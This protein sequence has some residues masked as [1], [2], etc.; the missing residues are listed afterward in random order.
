MSTSKGVLNY[1]DFI[2]GEDTRAML[3]KLYAANPTAGS[4]YSSEIAAAD[5]AHNRGKEQLKENHSNSKAALDKSKLAQKRAASYSYAKLLNYL[6][7]QLKAQGLHGQGVSQSALLGAYGNYRNAVSGIDTKH[8]DAVTALDAAYKTDLAGLDETRDKAYLGALQNYMTRVD[9]SS[10]R[11]ALNAKI[12]EDL[13]MKFAEAEAS[14]DWTEARKYFEKVKGFL[15]EDTAAFYT[16][17]VPEMAEMPVAG[18]NENALDDAGLH[19]FVYDYNAKHVGI[20][21]IQ[22]SDAGETLLPD[23][24]ISTEKGRSISESMGVYVDDEQAE[25]VAAV[26][27]QSASWGADK[28][29]T[30]VKFNV[31]LVN[32]DAQIY[33]FYNGRW[34]KTKLSGNAAGAVDAKEYIEK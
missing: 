22:L 8:T 34:F 4:F 30:L 27:K 11:P 12:M 21:Q 28:N 5:A 17:K 25:A 2:R 15:D 33:M 32:G 16:T 3:E 23:A 19:K 29:G 20:D 14:G 7:E 26:L 1:S 31:G 13:E 18:A 9:N 10:A 24:N 6:P